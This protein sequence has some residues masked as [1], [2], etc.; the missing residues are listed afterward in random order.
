M[1]KEYLL[2]V[3]L[4]TSGRPDS[5]NH[6]VTAEDRWP[7]ILQVAWQVYDTGGNLIKTEN[8]YVYDERVVIDKDSQRLHG[9]SKDTLASIGEERKTVMRQ[10]SRHL[11]RFQPTIVGHFVE[12]DSKMLQ[13]AMKRAGLKNIVK[14]LPHFCTMAATSEYSFQVNRT[15]PKLDELHLRLFQEK[16]ENM[17]NALSDVKAT[18]RCFFELVKR[19]EINPHE[20]RHSGF[21]KLKASVK[22]KTGCGLPVVFFLIASIIWM[23]L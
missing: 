4:E 17:H 18:A 20:L 22:H 21:D 1:K 8:H 5:L 3:D 7:Y 12:F 15:Y 11:R 10:L 19:G 9:L 14:D 13:V 23:L 16:M 2:F 6:P